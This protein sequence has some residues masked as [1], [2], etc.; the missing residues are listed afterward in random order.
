MNG[1]CERCKWY[2]RD[3]T[4]FCDSDYVICEECGRLVV[5]PGRSADVFQEANSIPKILWVGANT[6]CIRDVRRATYD[7]RKV[8]TSC[9]GMDVLEDYKCGF[10]MSIRKIK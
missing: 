10:R 5:S 6:T 2:F 9:E 8:V 3:L 1:I 4:R 7:P